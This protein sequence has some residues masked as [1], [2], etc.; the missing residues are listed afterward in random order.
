[1]VARISS[2]RSIKSALH[3]NESKLSA[4]KA[5]LLL[6]SRFG[7]NADELTARQ[8]LSRF[9]A[10]TGKNIKVKTNTLHISLNFAPGEQLAPATL[11]HLAA[12]Y[13]QRI[14][15]AEQPY[16]VYQHY[17]AGHPHIHIVTT[18]IRAN[19]RAISLHNIGRERSEPARK[20]LEHIYGLTV[21]EGRREKLELPAAPVPVSYGKSETKQAI[22][23]IVREVCGTYCYTSLDELNTA[24]RFY[25]V[26]ADRGRPGSLCWNRGGLMFSVVDKDGCKVGIPIA[27]SSIYGNPTLKSLERKMEV[28]RIAAVYK[29]KRLRN[30]AERL[31]AGKS[32]AAVREQLTRNNIT[33]H[34]TSSNG[35]TDLLLIDHRNRA[36]FSLRAE[37][38]D[39]ATAKNL[40]Q[41]GETD[42][43]SKATSL[44][45]PYSTASSALN[46][47]AG[48]LREL[49]ADAHANAEF[50]PAELMGKKKRRRKS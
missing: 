16:L 48:L 8:K 9:E 2:G 14:G 36:V 41:Q 25:N 30:A 20:A 35:E 4:G 32:P 43:H 42:N 13:M 5:T 6:A 24:L 23:N 19:G 44:S 45:I 40:L 47:S 39:I 21:A 17:D 18:S 28:N 1:M 37:G 49:T 31:I 38:F 46:I 26:T 34:H 22:S 33:Y 11:Q 50:L 7:C 12:E 15:F 10:L 29:R 27:A 3:Y